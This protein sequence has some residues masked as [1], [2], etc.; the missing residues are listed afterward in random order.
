MHLRALLFLAVVVAL[1]PLAACGP[2]LAQR[3]TAAKP[4]IDALRA[5]HFAEARTKAAEVLRQDGDNPYAHLV[6]AISLYRKV[7]HDLMTDLPALLLGAVMARGVNDRYLHFALEGA[8][9]NL[10]AVDR[11]LSRVERYPELTFDLCLA[12]W[13][14][15]WNRNGRVDK[16]DR[17][18]LEIEVDADGKPYPADDPRRRPT[19]KLDHGDVLWAR[20]FLSFQRA[21]L[22]IALAYNYSDLDRVVP[23]LMRNK[24]GVLTLKLEHPERIAAARRLIL[25][26]LDLADRAR[27][28]YLAETDDEREWVP[29]PRQKSHPLPLPVDDALY[30]TWRD[31]VGDLRRLVAGEEGISVAELAQLGKHTWHSP[32]AGYLDLGSLLARPKDIVVDF[33]RLLERGRDD[34]E[35]TEAALHEILGSA[36]VPQMKPS[37]LLKRLQRMK[38]EVERGQETMGR[39]LRYLIWLN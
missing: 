21:L 38:G 13:E 4:A 16:R 27:E 3:E 6:D 11:S 32:P 5:A 2:S 26:G 37:P 19:F 35:L 18:L 34:A 23:E 39:K 8:E 33:G 28:A 29:N 22:D 17:A 10:A 15:D 1:G 30:Q 9:R 14:V 20:A 25:L 31:V 12:C 7:T 24:T 36:Y